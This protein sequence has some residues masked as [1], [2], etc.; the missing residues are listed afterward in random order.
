MSKAEG[1]ELGEVGG[2]YDKEVKRIAKKYHPGKSEAWMETYLVNKKAISLVATI[3]FHFQQGSHE[4]VLK[5]F[6]AYLASAWKTKTDFIGG[7][8]GPRK[9][10]KEEDSNEQN[11]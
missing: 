11:T 2:D 7:G 10:F 5:M 8:Y 9:W 4:T 3:T 6:E 1:K